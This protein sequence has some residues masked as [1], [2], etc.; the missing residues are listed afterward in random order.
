MRQRDEARRV[1]REG[2]DR[3][4]DAAA[5]GLAQKVALRVLAD[6]QRQL[7]VLSSARAAARATAGALPARRQVAAGAAARVAV[8]HRHDRDPRGVVE[9]SR[10]MPSQRRSWSPLLSFHGTPVWC[11]VRLGAWPTMSSLALRWPAPPA[12]GP[13]AGARRRRAA[14]DFGEKRSMDFFGSTFVAALFGE[15]TEERVELG[16]RRGVREAV[17][18]AL[19]GQRARGTQEAAP[20]RARQRRRPR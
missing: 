12:A 9:G 3:F 4:G 1:V 11:T 18:A 16:A 15:R 14:P 13:A 6:E 19:V 20:G 10:S 17:E 8:A 2:L 5:R 7:D